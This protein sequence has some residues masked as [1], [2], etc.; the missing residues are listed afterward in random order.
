M[1]N[2]G[3]ITAPADGKRPILERVLNRVFRCSHRQQTRPITLKGETFAICL[4]CGSHVPYSLEVLQPKKPVTKEAVPQSPAAL[5]KPAPQPSTPP[6]PAASAPKSAA[7]APKPAVAPKSSAPAPKTP[8]AP[9]KRSN[10]PMP[11]SHVRGALRKWTREGV[12]LGLLAVGFAGGIYYS[13]QQHQAPVVQAVV[14]PPAPPKTEQAAV[15][16]QIWSVPAL[17]QPTP[18]EAGVPETRPAHEARRPN[19]PLRLQSE[20]RFVLLAHEADA[21]LDLSKHPGKLKELIQAGALLSVRRGTA[22]RIVE[23]QERVV[24]VAILEGPARGEEG[25]VSA[26]RVQ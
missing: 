24:H 10:A 1:E 18:V 25:W 21:A 17:P 22:V 7:P 12:W 26:T 8:A 19:E 4:D 14:Q 6:K 2:V 23:K 5:K 16:P 13:G 20:G 9:P 3:S 11:V 15:P